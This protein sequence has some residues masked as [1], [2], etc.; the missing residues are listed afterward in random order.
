MPDSDGLITQIPRIGRYARANE[1]EDWRFRNYLKNHPNLTGAKL[2]AMVREETEFVWNRIDCTKCANCCKVMQPSVDGG[3]IR[4]LAKRLKM[5]PK[6]FEAEYVEPGEM[7]EKQFKNAPCRFLG[8]DGACTVYEDRP[9]ACQDFPYLHKDFLS[10]SM[11]MYSNR[12]VCPIV[13]NVWQ[14]VKGRFW[15]RSR[16]RPGRR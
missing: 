2:N 4:R 6:E 16:N 5:T 8:D 13:F 14:R 11:M 15:T 3:D 1:D 7:G 12:E 9:K 10:R